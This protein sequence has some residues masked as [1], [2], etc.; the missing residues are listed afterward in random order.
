[1]RRFQKASP[2]SQSCKHNLHSRVTSS[3]VHKQIHTLLVV[4]KHTYG[5]PSRPSDENLIQVG[6]H[7]AYSCS[8]I[9]ER[10]PA[11]TEICNFY[12]NVS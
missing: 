7:A 5:L 9:S 4:A 10:N 3:A 1:V 2:A 12:C 6:K 11:A 8:R